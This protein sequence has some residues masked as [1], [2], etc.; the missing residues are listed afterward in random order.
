[1]RDAII[2]RILALTDEQLELLVALLQKEEDEEAQ[3]RHRTSL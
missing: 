1:M 3:E 2:K